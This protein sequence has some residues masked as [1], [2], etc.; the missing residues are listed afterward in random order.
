MVNYKVDKKEELSK[1]L[2][3]IDSC[4][5]YPPLT[6]NHDTYLFITTMKAI[7]TILA[8]YLEHRN[9]T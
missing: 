6:Q 3:T 7:R 4:L 5:N 8:D 2:A 1:A 9:D